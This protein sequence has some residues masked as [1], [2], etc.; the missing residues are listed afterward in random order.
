VAAVPAVVLELGRGAGALGL[1]TPRELDGRD[2]EIS[3]AGTA[4]DWPGRDIE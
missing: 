1:R 2:N 3:R 4:A